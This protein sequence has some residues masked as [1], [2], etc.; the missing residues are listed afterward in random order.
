MM[1]GSSKCGCFGMYVK[2]TLEI[3]WPSVYGL[4]SLKT[5]NYTFLFF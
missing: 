4:F 1:I 3:F 2:N 5:S